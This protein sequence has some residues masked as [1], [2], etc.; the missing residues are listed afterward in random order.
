MEKVRNVSERNTCLWRAVD[1][2]AVIGV[3]VYVMESLKLILVV[4]VRK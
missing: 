1:I 3:V 2:Y 4:I